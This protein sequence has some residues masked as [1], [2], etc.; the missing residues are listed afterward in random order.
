[1]QRNE[2]I[3]LTA[4]VL[5]LVV[6]L[7]DGVLGLRTQSASLP[8]L[9]PYLSLAATVCGLAWIRLRL[10]RLSE[11]ESRDTESAAR[12]AEST[13]LF[14]ADERELDP[15]SYARLRRQ[16]ERWFIPV[17]A[18]LLAIWMG[19]WAYRLLQSPALPWPEADQRLFAASF[20]IGQAFI[21]FLFGRYL[22][23]LSRMDDHRL[24]RGPAVYLLLAS[25]GSMAVGIGHVI[26]ET[27]APRADVI[28]RTILA[29]Y[30]AVLV[31]EWVLHTVAVIYRPRRVDSLLTS[32]ESRFS[33]WW[34]DPSSWTS[35]LA[36]TLDYQF[37]FGV[38][39]TW[40]YRFIQKAL[41]PLVLM[42]L[43]LLY[44][45]SCM[46]VLGPSEVGVREKFGQPL[47][48]Q[49]TPR[50]IGSGFH[51]KWPWPFEQIRRLPAKQI[52]HT[53]IGYKLHEEN[54]RPD[55]ILWTRPHYEMED[56]FIVASRQWAPQA[57]EDDAAVPV[58]FISVSIPI[59]YRI[60]DPY[61]YLYKHAA[62]DATLRDLALRTLTR[63][64]AVSDLI[65]LLGEARTDIA[66]QL[67]LDLQKAVDQAQL[68]LEILYVGF[69]GAHPPIAVADAFE[70]V[71]GALEEKETLALNAS[72]YRNRT[73]PMAD[74]EGAA[75]VSQAQADSAIRSEGAS[76]ESDQFTTRLT[77]HREVP[78][79]YA[80]RLH[81]DALR[82]ALRDAR[83]YVVTS[84]ADREVIIFNLEE[85]SHPDLYDFGPAFTEDPIL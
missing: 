73:L 49:G 10:K 35:G 29:F 28:V 63:M 64:L 31:V 72:A 18:P 36:H 82:N 23:A 14:G 4:A 16:L 47:D 77:I 20:A 66:A 39:D 59:T 33:A 27:I 19:L 38:S 52:L 25:L 60:V 41:G 54:D 42:Q 34:T 5:S 69:Q 83:K 79:V 58:N 57:A 71:V 11:E 53:Q 78:R 75:L 40:F 48:K 30:L 62:P 74:A 3:L 37:G 50:I 43:A 26:S 61:T 21:F 65:E 32:Y 7:I 17:V 76:A 46:A 2:H 6:F 56:Q 24:L 45:L 80:S 44:A 8:A 22:L 13:S 9:F 15:F 68:G 51:F 67:T 55:L 81:L 1:M 70:S 85:K 12:S 84:P